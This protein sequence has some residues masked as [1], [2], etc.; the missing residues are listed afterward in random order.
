[1]SRICLGQGAH[2]GSPGVSNVAQ[3]DQLLDLVESETQL[4]RPLDEPDHAD[5][6]WRV[7]PV[8]RGGPPRLLE[9]AA[10]LVVAKRLD[11]HARSARDF[12]DSKAPSPHPDLRPEDT[13]CTQV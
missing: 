12:S 8:T 13:A 4:L 11:A 7:L 3:C 1:M 9:Q 2:L 5:C 10:P 6:L